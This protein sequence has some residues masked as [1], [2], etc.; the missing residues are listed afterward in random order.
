LL[1]SV[2]LADLY[3]DGFLE[4]IAV[5]GNKGSITIWRPTLK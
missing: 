5:S 2:T 1:H 3:H 4:V